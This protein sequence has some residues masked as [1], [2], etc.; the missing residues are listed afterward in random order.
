MMFYAQHFGVYIKN[1]NA[2]SAHFPCRPGVTDVSDVKKKEKVNHHLLIVS[3]LELLLQF[4][5]LR[6]S[7][8]LSLSSK[9]Q[10]AETT[11]SNTAEETL[12][13]RQDDLSLS[14]S[15]SVHSFS[16][17][18]LTSSHSLPKPHKQPK[19]G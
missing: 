17:S 1:N 9:L 14:L 8:F 12:G 13:S 16:S 7:R 6:C 5:C 11:S 19:R 18:H 2:D 4:N 10:S 3:F 15:S